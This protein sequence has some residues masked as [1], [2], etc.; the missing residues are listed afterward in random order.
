MRDARNP[1]NT[2][3]HRPSPGKKPVYPKGREGLQR[4]YFQTIPWPLKVVRQE[5]QMQQQHRGSYSWHVPPYTAGYDLPF[6]GHW[7]MLFTRSLTLFIQGCKIP[8]PITHNDN[9]TTIQVG[10]LLKELAGELLR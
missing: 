3:T 1:K 4:R 6:R 8:T 2:K 5:G 7:G 10:S 9:T